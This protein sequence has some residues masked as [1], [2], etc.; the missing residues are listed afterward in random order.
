MATPEATFAITPAKLG[1]P[2]NLG[3]LLTVLNTIPLVVAKEMLFTARPI[4]S[5]QAYNIGMI[6]HIREAD[7]IEAYVYEL[8]EH[9]VHTAPLSVSVMKEELRLLSSARSITPE[10]FEQI[11]GLRRTVY[12][13]KD[14]AEGIAAFLE[15]RP[16][17]FQGE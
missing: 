11:Q 13:S 4:P 7:Q 16:P 14:Y 6:N 15:K 5:Y 17:R 12:D 3:G 1:V 2:Y 9:V 8:A 10:L